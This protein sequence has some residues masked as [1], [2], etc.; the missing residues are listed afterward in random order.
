MKL[1]F[2]LKHRCPLTRKA[3]IN[4]VW[5]TVTLV[6]GNKQIVAIATDCIQI[7]QRV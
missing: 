5:F 1:N 6:Y 4:R 2:E 7:Q 3:N